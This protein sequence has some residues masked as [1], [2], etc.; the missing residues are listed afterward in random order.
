M[1]K[2]PT[3][4]ASPGLPQMTDACPSHSGLDSDSVCDASCSSC[5]TDTFNQACPCHDS[6]S[7]QQQ[8]ERTNLTDS[9]MN[10]WLAMSAGGVIAAE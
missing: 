10:Y 7:E 1:A 6:L 8:G 9:K 2:A 4:Q 3:L 5:Q